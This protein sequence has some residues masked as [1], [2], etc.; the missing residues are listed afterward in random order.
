[1]KTDADTDRVSKKDKIQTK[2]TQEDSLRKKWSDTKPGD[3]SLVYVLYI[4][5]VN[6]CSSVW[7]IP[8]NSSVKSKT[9]KLFVT[10]PGKHA[11]FSDRSDWILFDYWI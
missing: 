7:Q 9:H 11:T 8:N 5:E 2:L 6:N 3:K 1:M 4:S 10:L